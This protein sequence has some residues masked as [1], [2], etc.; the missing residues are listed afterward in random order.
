MKAPPTTR[1]AFVIRIHRFNRI[2]KRF[3]TNNLPILYLYFLLLMMVSSNKQ[4]VRIIITTVF[5]IQT[6]AHTVTNFIELFFD[7]LFCFFIAIVFCFI[8]RNFL[9]IF[10]YKRRR[11]TRRSSVVARILSILSKRIQVEGCAYARVCEYVRSIV[12]II[13]L[14]FTRIHQT[15][16]FRTL[17]LVNVKCIS[18][19]IVRGRQYGRIDFDRPFRG[20]PANPEPLRLLR[21]QTCRRNIIQII[22]NIYTIH[23]NIIIFFNCIKSYKRPITDLN[24]KQRYGDGRDWIEEWDRI[25]DA[26]SYVIHSDKCNSN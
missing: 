20:F 2:H 3:S 13:L 25:Y 21:R 7:I 5:Y 19:K 18:Y 14:Y 22:Q 8:L 4:R 24:H 6:D 17:R 15:T 1:L 26:N 16:Q 11:T 9:K 12:C 10:Y 23:H